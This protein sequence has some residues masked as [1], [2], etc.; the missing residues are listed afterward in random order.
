MAGEIIG[1]HEELRSL[2]TFL[3]ELPAGGQALLLEGD[4]GIGKSTLW[5]EGVQARAG[6]TTAS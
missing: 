5:H 2:R 1:R 6:T 4:P 3:A